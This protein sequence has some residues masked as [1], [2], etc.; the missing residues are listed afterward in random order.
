MTPALSI[1]VVT[2][3]R[4]TLTRTLRSIQSQ[5]LAPQDEVLVVGNSTFIEEQAVAFGCRYIKDGPFGEWGQRERQAAMAHARGTH[6][7]FMDDDDYYLAGAFD[8]IRAAIVAHPDV[9]IMFKM[10]G[11]RGFRLWIDPVVEVGNVSGTQFV[12]PN[13]AEKLGS[14]GLSHEG[15]FDF[16]ESTLAHYPEHALIW[17][18]TLIVG[19]RDEAVPAG[20]APKILVTE[21]PLRILLVHPGASWST[22][23]VYDG[24]LYG[25]K[26][27]GVVVD[28]YRL[29]TRIDVSHKALH[30]LWRQKK[31]EGQTF[32]KPSTV[33][34]IYHAGIGALEMALRKQADVVLVVSAMLLHPDVVRLMKRAGLRVTVLFTES[35]YDIEQ[36]VRLAKEIDGCWTTERSSVAELRSVNPRTGYLR[37]GWHPEKHFV[38][39]S[40]IIID[41]PAHDVVFVGTGFA[42]RA[43]FLNAIDWTGID[44]GL[45]GTW[46]DAGLNPQVR[47]CV[48]SEAI[49]NDTASALYRRAKIGLNLYRRLKGWAAKGRTGPCITHAESLSPRAYE[50]AA[51]GAFHL[52]EDRTEVREVFGDLVPT[53][54]TP[55]EASRLM[56][57]WLTDAA[58]RQ[59]VAAQLPACVA[60]ASWIDRAKTV[61]G[62]LQALLTQ[63]AA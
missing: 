23:D 16:I 50:L 41:T 8:A 38:G 52:S 49:S 25:L 4:E 57:A 33:D 15:D 18:A 28:S 34:I 1:L 44:F 47:A 20:A 5:G 12:V 14:W 10:F 7:L 36:E 56:R 27:H 40:R 51:C 6:L 31:K 60:E 59:H 39:V 32:P 58:G 22:A 21:R 63:K 19:C 35:P 29:D 37:H 2:S 46:K 54:R 24:L 61:I 30:A 48:R 9:P 26:Y 45:Y 3:G 11:L 42:E 13:I 17:D 62:D 43:T 53:F 55:E